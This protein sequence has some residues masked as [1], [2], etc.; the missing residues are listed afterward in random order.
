[1]LASDDLS[2]MFAHR[3][4]AGTKADAGSRRGCN[5]TNDREEGGRFAD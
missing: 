3:D 2:E 1:V 4:S 5:E